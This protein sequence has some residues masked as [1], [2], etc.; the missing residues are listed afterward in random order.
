MRVVYG[1]TWVQRTDGGTQ[2]RTTG[3]KDLT[4]SRR[5]RRMGNSGLGFRVVDFSNRTKEGTIEVC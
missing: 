1:N 4:V 2:I 5:V 3:E